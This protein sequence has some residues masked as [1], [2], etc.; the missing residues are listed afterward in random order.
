MERCLPS[1]AT[2]R[3]SSSPR[4]T[5]RSSSTDGAC[6]RSSATDAPTCTAPSRGRR[7][8]TIADIDAAAPPAGAV[9]GVATPPAPSRR[10][11]RRQ[12]R[13]RRA[14]DAHRRRPA[15]R[16]GGDVGGLQG[17]R[18]ALRRPLLQHLV[19][20]AGRHR[21]PGDAPR[22]RHRRR[23]V[24]TV[25]RGSD[26]LLIT[27]LLSSAVRTL[28]TAAAGLAIAFVVGFGLALL[29]LRFTLLRRG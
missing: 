6:C 29:L 18:P 13:L 11:A 20:A 28:V 16:A 9:R 23:P 22:A 17:V 27:S 5:R 8:M 26:Q 19:G 10:R 15:R 14:H 12:G 24:R 4:S 1:L 21:R 7:N 2:T 25:Q 3:E